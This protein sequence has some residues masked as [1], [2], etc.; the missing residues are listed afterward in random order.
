LNQATQLSDFVARYTLHEH[1]TTRARNPLSKAESLEVAEEVFIN[2]DVPTHK[3]LQYLNDSGL[4][5]FTKY[6]MRIQKTILHLYRQNPGRAMLL[7]TLNNML[8]GIPSLMDA[9]F[10]SRLGNNPFS[11]G[12][13][14]LPQS[15][16]E[17]VP[18]KLMMSPFN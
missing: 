13:L 4:M 16:G 6:Y 15:V 5:M 9:Q 8:G 1:Q 11:A 2:Y 17:I 14:N 12:A 3:G 7:I 10:F 18:I